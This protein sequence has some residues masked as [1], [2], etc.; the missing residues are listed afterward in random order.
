MKN[1]DV[2]LD[3]VDPREVYGN[4]LERLKEIKAKYDPTI[5]FDKNVVIRP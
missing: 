4:N 3:D 1:G 5:F 2:I